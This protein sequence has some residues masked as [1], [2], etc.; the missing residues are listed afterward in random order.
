[1]F[2]GIVQELGTVIAVDSANGLKRLRLQAPQT[3][4]GLV[5]GESVAVNGVC[6][7]AVQVRRGLIVFEMI[8]ET[9]RLT[10]LGHLAAG[11]RVNLERSLRLSD[12]LGGHLVLGHVDGMGQVRRVVQQPSQVQL[13]IRVDRRV[14]R[15]LVPKGPV[16][17]DGVSLTVG[18]RRSPTAFSIYLIPET[19]RRTT[20]S[21]RRAGDR[22]NIE[23]DYVAKLILERT[24][25]R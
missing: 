24:P 7:T 14:G 6:L 17:V 12:R 1:M 10:T 11:S 13:D 16:A 8:A 18:E 21:L 23:A 9:A 5:V 2:T 4:A 25:G 19:S 3:A 20:L 22:V 15:F